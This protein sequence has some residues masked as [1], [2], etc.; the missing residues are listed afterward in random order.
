MD[1]KS[2]EAQIANPLAARGLRYKDEGGCF[3]SATSSLHSVAV[4]QQFAG[5]AGTYSTVVGGQYTAFV[6]RDILRSLVSFVANPSGKTYSYSAQFVTYSS[7]SPYLPFVASAFSVTAD[8]QEEEFLDF[9]SFPDVYASSTSSSYIHPHGPVLY[10]GL[11]LGHKFAYFDVA[12]IGTF[13]QT[14]TTT[15][16]FMTAYKWDGQTAQ[17]YGAIL[18]F[19]SGSVTFTPTTQGY[20]A[21]SYTDTASHSN[22][23]S[24]VIAG[25]GDCFGHITIPQVEG[26]LLNL[27]QSR[28]LASSL[29]LSNTASALNVE[30]SIWAAQFPGSELWYNRTTSTSIGLA[31]EMYEGRAATG[32]YGWLKPYKTSDFD[33]RPLI[34][35]QNGIVTNCS[36]SLENASPFMVFVINTV[37]TGTTYPGLDFLSTFATA[38]EFVTQSQW[39][40]AELPMLGTLERIQ[41]IDRLERV[42]QFNENPTHLQKLYSTISSGARLLGKH[43]F[44]VSSALFKMSAA[45]KIINKVL[46]KSK[47]A[48]PVP[49]VPRA[50]ARKIKS[51]IPHKQ[52]RKTLPHKNA[53]KPKRI[54]AKK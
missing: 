15:T 47:K 32:V 54:H 24:L 9:Q 17:L 14:T 23:V 41:A 10:P 8:A 3:P 16:A 7:T 30:G 22:S 40:E 12:A 37:S 19:S 11:A 53:I 21:F 20:Y 35:Q 18:P 38:L 27:Q 25:V 51:Q 5:N 49:Y 42:P 28:I 2:F 6:M 36:F 31:R 48:K 44:Q 43:K 1:I 46:A 34:T 50:P 39:Y 45:T 33:Y 52:G 13:S 26:Q 4:V 29:L